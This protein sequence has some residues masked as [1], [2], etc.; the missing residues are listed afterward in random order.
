MKG[1]K[2][3]RIRGGITAPKGFFASATEAGIKYSNREDM[4][5]IFSQ[6]SAVLAGVF[7]KNRVKAAPVKLC[8]EGVKRGKAQA[9]VLIVVV[10]MPVLVNGEWKMQGELLR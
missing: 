4:A 6:E 1:N 2:I 9:I 3:V 5:L 7:T 10:Q 8:M